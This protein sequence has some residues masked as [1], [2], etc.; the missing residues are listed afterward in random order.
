MAPF[1]IK[2][3]N[4]VNCIAFVLCLNVTCGIVLHMYWM[5]WFS[6]CI[7]M[8]LGKFNW[9]ISIVVTLVNQNFTRYTC[10]LHT[11]FVIEYLYTTYY[12][13]FILNYIVTWHVIYY[14]VCTRPIDTIQMFIKFFEKFNRKKSIVLTLCHL[15]L[16]KIHM[17]LI[18]SIMYRCCIHITKIEC[19]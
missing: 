5:S 8:F 1:I 9:K 4:T 12:K 14:Y 2:Y 18:Y 3:L 17:F 15:T 6:T 16:Y 13:A 11:P 10:L 19:T 7:I